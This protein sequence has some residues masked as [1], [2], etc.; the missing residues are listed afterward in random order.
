MNTYPIPE[1][2]GHKYQGSGHALAA[3][4]AGQVVDI[5]YLRDVLPDFNG[6]IVSVLDDDRLAPTARYLSALGS[7]SIGTVV[8]GEFVEL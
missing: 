5:V 3:I 4:T 7:V 6:D 2:L 1:T 8:R